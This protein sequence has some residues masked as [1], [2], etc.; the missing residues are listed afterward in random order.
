MLHLILG[1]TGTVGSAVVR[2]LLKRGERVRVVTRSREKTAAVPEGVEGVVGDLR[3]PKSYPAIFDGADTVFLLNGLSEAELQEGLCSLNEAKRVGAKRLVYLSVHDVEK[4]PHIPHFAS[5]IAIE[6]AIKASG[7]P[8]TMIR[9]NN[10][11]QNDHW[12]Q[13]AILEYGVYPQ[14]I[15]PTGISRVDVRDIAEASA[16]ALMHS[17]FENRSFTLAGPEP[18]T[19]PVCA[20]AFS[21]ALGRPIQYGGDDLEAWGAQAEGMLPA[22]L[23]YD[24]KLMY[25]L[26]QND[27]LT[28]T[29]EQLAECEEIVGHPM[30]RYGDFVRE[31]AQSWRANGTGA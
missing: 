19:G 5:K 25:G 11:Y 22:W 13:Q 31:T 21:E 1:G 8:Y 30:R 17:R 6:S 12:Y 20:A 23:V 28:A 29:R 2:E 14:P 3:D 4:G 27:G 18:V 15:G 10:F 9:P 16:N 24:F 26:F 7:I